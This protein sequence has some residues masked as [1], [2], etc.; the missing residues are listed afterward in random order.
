MSDLELNASKKVE[1]VQ[2]P[3]PTGTT[4]LNPPVDKNKRR[5]GDDGPLSKAF[6]NEARDHLSAQ[7]ARLFYSSGLPF[8]VARNPYFISAFSYAANTN[9]S[10]YIPPSYNAIRTTM[11]QREK[12]N[13]MKLLQ[14]IKDTWAEKGV[15]IVTDGWTDG[16][17]RPLINFM[18]TSTAGPIFL[19]AIDTTGEFKDRH[20][21][22]NLILSAIDEVGAQNVVQVITDNA[23]VC[24]AAGSI[25]ESMHPHIFWTPCVVHTLNLA[26]KNIC[27]PSPGPNN[28]VAYDE[29][30]W[31]TKVYE[32]ASTI[33]KFIL[34]HSMRFAM[35]KQFVHLRLLSICD[36]RFA[37]V[38]VMLKRMQAVKQGL[39]S[40]VINEQWSQY[41]EDNVQKAAAVKDKILDDEFWAQ[42]EYILKFTEPIYEMLRSCDTDEPN[43][44]LVYDKWD[45][46]IDRV[47]SIIYQHEGKELTQ[48]SS[49]YD[50]VYNILTDRWSK[51]NTPL[52]CLAHSLNPRYYCREWLDQYPARVAP[53]RDNEICQERNKCFKNYFQDVSERREAIAEFV[54]F[55]SAEGEFGQFDSLLDRWNLTPKEWWVT[56]GSSIPKLQSIALKLFSQP[57]SSSSAERNWSTYGFIQS[58]KR[59]KLN[60]KRAEDL[61]YIH[62][63]LRLLS[64]NNKS[65]KEGPTKMWDIGGD[66]FD[67]V[68]GAGILEVASLSLDEP[69]LEGALFNDHGEGNIF[70]Q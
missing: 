1:S 46:M 15:S 25:V 56:Y 22:A 40:M 18:A 36:T 27:S 52:H 24:K 47:K 39:L 58:M 10:G 38:I 31:I 16:Q 65:Y 5:R 30:V 64:R 2:V 60:P 35:Y 11:L 33:K 67:L 3:F 23:P 8:N 21:I 51:S 4:N 42:V 17:R 26:L 12:S 7:I 20:Y 48:Y 57:T 69:E 43:L 59:N 70:T 34:T 62:T 63:N 28:E 66:G 29:C 45:S 50:V 44:H 55:S 19:K 37:S 68:D 41:R 54:K 6:N 13:I 14:P 49:F 32:D 53:H 9:I 61:V